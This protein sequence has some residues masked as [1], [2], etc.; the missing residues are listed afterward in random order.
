VVPEE[1]R[2]QLQVFDAKGQLL[3]QRTDH[4]RAGPNDIRIPRGHLPAG[5]LYYRFVSPTHQAT[6]KMILLE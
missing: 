2:G 3:Q 1:V 4:Y 5:V 6:R